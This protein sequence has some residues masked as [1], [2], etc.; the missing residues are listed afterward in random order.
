MGGFA[1]RWGMQT[2]EIFQQEIREILH[3]VGFTTEQFGSYDAAGDVFGHP[4]QVELD[5]ITKND[6]LM[7]VEIKPFLDWENT[8][9]F[10]RKVAFY[11]RSTSRQVDR[12][13]I[14]TPFVDN[15]A[16]EI[17]LR[18]G[19]EICTDITALS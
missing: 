17:G 5:V 19:V 11:T 7:V 12:K 13:L 15:R 2:I 16:K 8:Y 3:E 6:K 9:M 4:D 14:V 1:T 10:D 18:L